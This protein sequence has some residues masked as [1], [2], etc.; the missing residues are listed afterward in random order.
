MPIA[1]NY[2][3]F[4]WSFGSTKFKELWP[5][6][7]YVLERY[8]IDHVETNDLAVELPTG[9]GKTL[10]ALLVAEAWRQD[11]KK[12]AILSANKTLA[13]QMESEG[14]ALGIPVILME[15]RG[16]DIPPRNRR[17]YQRSKKTAIMNYWVY[18]NQNP[19]IDH[20]DL[21][22]M[23]D[24]HLAEHCFHSLWSLEVNRHQHG[25]LFS[26]LMTEISTRFPEYTVVQDALANS[27][28]N[29]NPPE[30]LSFI[31]QLEI[32]QRL[33]EIIDTSPYLESDNDLRFRWQRI[34]S[35]LDEANIYLANSSI[36][37][38]P[39]IYPLNSNQHY[40]GSQQRLYFSATIGEPADLCR[41]LGV[42]KIVKMGIPP[43]HSQ[44][45]S[46]RRLVVMNRIEDSDLPERLQHAFLVSLRRTPKSIW[47]FSSRAEVERLRPIVLE[48]LNS[49]GFVG[50]ESWVLTSLGDEID[51]FKTSEKGHLFV[52]GRFDGMDFKEDE[53]RLVVVATLPRAIN[54]QEE[55]ICAYLRDAS[56]MQR[57][58]N[59]RIIQ[60]LGRCNRA[61]DDYAV[62]VL[63][64]RRFATHFGRESNRVGVPPNII[65]EIDMAE[66][67]SELEISDLSKKIDAFLSQD[68]NE[69][70]VEHTSLLQ[71]VPEY[72]VGNTEVELAEAEVLGWTALFD[73]QNYTIAA[74]RFRRC[75][76]LSRE[77][78]LLEIGAFYGWCLAKALYLSTAKV[79]DGLLEDSLYVF[80]E[81]IRR[82]GFLSWFNRMRASLNRAR[83]QPRT[84]GLEAEEYKDILVWSFDNLLER[85][86]RKFDRYCEGV[87]DDLQADTHDQYCQGLEKMGRLLGYDATRPRYGSATDNRWRGVFGGYREVITI[88]AKI[89]HEPSGYITAGHVGQAHNQIERARSEFSPHGYQV[90]GVIITHLT[91]LAGD[92]ESSAGS[93]RCISKDDIFDLWEHIYQLIVQYRT[94]WSLDNIRQRQIAAAAIRPLLPN[95]G[96]LHRV[97][98]KDR[99]WVTRE[100]LL[101]EWPRH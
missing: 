71:D 17:D 56:F 44:Q 26:S 21:L 45:T 32:S 18:F 54:T 65:A 53:C 29:Y 31:D 95:S 30:L 64:D 92:A 40:A 12:V 3:E 69:Y 42:R 51:Q 20:S 19:V 36:W 55:F 15:G 75:W 11:G 86:G 70:D 57:R 62:Y 23:D 73:S 22:I 96:W 28:S 91:R 16:V 10:I 77:Q 46:G 84:V 60:A 68:F 38:R 98:V 6:Q 27:E 13:R 14:E 34:R 50:H 101:E 8:S 97:L 100:S 99:R 47:M 9:A 85:T 90:A 4:L 61:S 24:A 89:E 52:A 37:I 5:A 78:N 48:W 63:A 81:A 93:I 67:M 7:R 1:R 35:K 74:D 82:G 88:E 83:R 33:M 41:R 79:G 72:Q 76:E 66:D 49:N 59:Q 43:E 87:A 39:Y 94:Q 58:L 80:E 2:D 25:S